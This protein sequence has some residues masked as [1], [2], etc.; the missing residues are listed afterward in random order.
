MNKPFEMQA[1]VE[2]LKA[3]GMVEAEQMAKLVSEEVFAWVEESLALESNPLYKIAIPV[4]E[5]L[6]PIALKAEDK[7]DGVEGN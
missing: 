2:R 4:I 7:I 1:L 3:K 5:F 6:K